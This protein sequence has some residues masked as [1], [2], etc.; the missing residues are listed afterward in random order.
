MDRP[1]SPEFRFRQRLEQKVP[2]SRDASGK[3]GPEI[4]WTGQNGRNSQNAVRYPLQ[5]GLCLNHNALQFFIA[6][7]GPASGFHPSGEF[8]APELEAC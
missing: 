7:A 3:R 6:A 4:R 1:T 8:G 5:L 2:V